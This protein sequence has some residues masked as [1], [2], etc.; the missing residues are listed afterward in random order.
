M[1]DSL[2]NYREV[3]PKV[4]ISNEESLHY[5]WRIIHCLEL[6]KKKRFFSPMHGIC[7]SGPG[8][9]LVTQLCPTLCNPM[10]CSLP[11]S[12]VHGI[13]R[14]YYWL[15]YTGVGYHPF[16]QGMEEILRNSPGNSFLPDPRSEPGSSALR[17]HALPSESPGKLFLGHPGTQLGCVGYGPG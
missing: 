15:W 5:L 11:D 12:S 9:A 4:K 6:K 3:P 16:L 1:N 7:F 2:N 10:D 17:V 13:L 8:K 14:A